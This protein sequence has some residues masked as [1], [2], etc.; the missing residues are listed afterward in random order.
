[1]WPG[2]LADR[3]LFNVAFPRGRQLLL[4]VGDA[5][6]LERA[7]FAR[8]HSAQLLGTTVTPEMVSAAAVQVLGKSVALASNDLR[9]ALDAWAFVERRTIPGGPAPSAIRAHLTEMRKHQLAPRSR[10]HRHWGH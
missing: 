2:F 8:I 1:M 4:I 7:G 5:V 9:A 10:C 3:R 6:M